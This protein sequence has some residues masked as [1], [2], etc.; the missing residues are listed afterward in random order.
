MTET[1]EYRKKDALRKKVLRKAIDGIRA[2]VAMAGIII[3]IGAAG[4]VD[5]GMMCI[6]QMIAYE[7][8]GLA[9]LALA[10]M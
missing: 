5:F 10:V 3:M 1:V 7:S 8:A 2:I 9:M 4:S 6:G